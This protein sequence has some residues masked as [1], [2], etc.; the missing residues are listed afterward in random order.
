MN[1]NESYFVVSPGG[2]AFAWHGKGAAESEKAYCEK[3]GSVLDCQVT[4]VQEGSE[5]DAFWSAVGGQTEYASDK[6]LG[7]APGFQP[8]LF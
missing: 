6:L 3:L 1:S 5:D 2:A 8:R 7:F 4:V